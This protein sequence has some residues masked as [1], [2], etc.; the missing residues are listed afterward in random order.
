MGD[1]QEERPSGIARGRPWTCAKAIAPVPRVIGAPEWR[2]IPGGARRLE[3]PVVGL[4]GA[5][6][7]RAW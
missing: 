6:S 5:L 4:A 3:T 2:P 1:E 7:R